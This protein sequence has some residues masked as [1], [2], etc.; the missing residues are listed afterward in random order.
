LGLAVVHGIVKSHNA[1]ISVASHPGEGTVFRLY[2]PAVD[3]P[4]ANVPPEP[5]ASKS[6]SD[7]GLHILY[8]DDEDALVSLGKRVLQRLGYRIA[9]FT[10][11]STA[12]AAFRSNP[13]H[14]DMVVTDFSMPG[15]TGLELARELLQLRPGLPL[16]LASGH[17]TDELKAEASA[18]GIMELTYKPYSVKELGMAVDR[19]ALV[20]TRKPT[21]R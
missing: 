15:M 14:Y 16:M 17:I 2:F 7:H 10:N 19:M 18:L 20:R 9:G 21:L 13:S 3:A 12:L 4:V 11:P 5:A 6:I 1:A 8:V